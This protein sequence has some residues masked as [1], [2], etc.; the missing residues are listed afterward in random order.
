MN[1]LEKIGAKD[2]PAFDAF[3]A[4]NA[5]DG[6]LFV[7][8]DD[9]GRITTLR[10]NSDVKVLSESL[11]ELSE[12]RT[13]FVRMG[14]VKAVPAALGKL[15]KLASLT[16]ER[17]FL[18]ELPKGLEALASLESLSLADNSLASLPDPF[19]LPNLV[20][21]DL[22]D[23]KLATVPKSVLAMPRLARLNLKGN[24]ISTLPPEIGKLARLESLVVSKAKLKA[25]P[26]EIGE[27]TA[28]RELYVAFN[29]IT[30]LPA[31]IARLA[32]LESLHVQGNALEALPPLFELPKL[33]KVIASRNK[34]KELDPRLV[35]RG[36]EKLDVADNPVG[37]FAPALQLRAQVRDEPYKTLV[38]CE[39]ALASKP[40]DADYRAVALEALR[41]I[42]SDMDEHGTANAEMYGKK[43]RSFFDGRRKD[44][45]GK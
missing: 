42:L 9:A 28:L 1:G 21:L 16:I 36:L 43:P 22:T 2:K 31:S 12:L 41:Y 26:S 25:L 17:H 7:E 6:N 40:D 39:A 13:L 23:N 5:L 15:G 30:E 20:A 33:R 37:G 19:P 27:L 3:V 38:R 4:E 45:E 29:K 10:S 14:K 44:L 34:I 18:K 32:E 11:A 24:P 8:T 35:E